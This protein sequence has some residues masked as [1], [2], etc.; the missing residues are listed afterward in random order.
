MKR[1]ISFALLGLVFG[2]SGISFAQ[3]YVVTPVETKRDLDRRVWQ[4]ERA[5]QELQTKIYQLEQKP[6][7]KFFCEATAWGKVYSG[8]GGTKLEATTNAKS[9]CAKDTNVMHCE[10]KCS[11]E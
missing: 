5:V 9:A 7:H 1:T 8:A 4:L 3:R 2:F 11:D 6:D 10:I